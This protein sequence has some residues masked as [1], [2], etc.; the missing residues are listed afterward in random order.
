MVHS[1]CLSMRPGAKLL[2]L[3]IVRPADAIGMDSW[4][5]PSSSIVG[6]ALSVCTAGVH[7]AMATCRKALEQRR[8]DVRAPGRYQSHLTPVACCLGRSPAN[9]SPA[10]DFGLAAHGRGPNNFIRLCNVL[11]VV[12]G[13]DTKPGTKLAVV[14]VPFL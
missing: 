6:I 1:A 4:C 3:A 13:K 10:Q 11:N 2:E 14:N 9:I 5:P 12:E 8:K 7:V